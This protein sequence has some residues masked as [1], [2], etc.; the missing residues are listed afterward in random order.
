MDVFVLPVTRDRYELYCEPAPALESDESTPR[1][2]LARQKRR[3]TDLLKTAEQRQYLR[4][5]DAPEEPKSWFARQQDRTMAWVAE[6]IAEQRLLWNLRGQTAATVIH[7][8]DLTAEQA[9]TLVRRE[10]ARDYERH[11][12]W[13]II[14]FIAFL[15][16]G[17]VLGPFFLLVPG[18]ANLPAA[19]FGFRVVGHWFSIRGA[20]QGMQHVAWSAQSSPAL[21]ELRDVIDLEP[22]LRVQRVQDIAMRL[23]LE[24]L[25]TYLERMAAAPAS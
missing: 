5:S 1:S 22:S 8:E 2:F 11:R 20:K 24:H 17:I 9:I 13:M 21:S 16:T 19:Y 4:G 15:F 10:L 18:I 12:R 25:A 6:R 23:R 3:I 14:D 7:P